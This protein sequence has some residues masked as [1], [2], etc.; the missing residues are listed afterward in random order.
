MTIAEREAQILRIKTASFQSLTTALDEK[1]RQRVVAVVKALLEAALVEE[2]KACLAQWTG[3]QPRRSGYFSR[4]TDTRYGRIPDLRVPK[5]RWGNRGRDWQILRRYQR[6]MPGLLD[7]L[8]YVYVMGL[9]LRDLQEALYILMGSV[10]S[11]GALNQVTLQVQGLLKQYQESPLPMTPEV[12]I[13][14]GVWVEIQYTREEFKVDRAGHRRRCRE[15][16]E[17]VILTVMG[18]YP[19]GSSSIVHFEVA[20]A[21]EEAQW[22]ALF[23]HLIARGLDPTAV[24]LIVSDGAKGL[25]TAMRR[26]F[27]SARQQR[28]ITHKVR[29]MRRYLTYDDLPEASPER[30]SAQLQRERWRELK[31]DAYDIYEAATRAEAQQRLAAFQ[32]K[33]QAREPKAVHAFAWGFKSTL[34]FYDFPAHLY[35]LIRTT[36]QLERFFRAFRTKADEIGAFPNETSCLTLFFLVAR[37]EHA[38]H[39]RP[40]MAKT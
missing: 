11:R 27:P 5:L 39:D 2:V 15:A 22:E 23:E 24:S 12:L 6:A 28:C 10:L 14:D 37:R 4:A 34:N 1:I 33:W 3:V 20:E 7:W 9:S 38:K 32:A 35:P 25:P 17:R 29:G 30:S 8:A 19:D 31:T 40:F 26:C 18:I 36:N 21:E 16:E 13:V